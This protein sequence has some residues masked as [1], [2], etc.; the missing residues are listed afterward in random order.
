MSDMNVSHLPTKLTTEVCAGQSSDVL[1][2]QPIGV[3]S[4]EHL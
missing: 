3:A 2:K 4:D 1:H